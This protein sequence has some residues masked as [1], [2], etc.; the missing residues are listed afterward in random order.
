MSEIAKEAAR[1]TYH[2]LDG[3]RGLAALAVVTHHAGWMFGAA[4]MQHA[5]MAVD[6]FFV[7]SGFVLAHAYEPRFKTGLGPLRFM[8]LRLIRL[9]PLYIAGVL[10]GAAWIAWNLTQGTEVRLAQAQPWTWGELHTA[11]LTNAFF[12]PSPS[13]GAGPP[14]LYP[15]NIPAWSLLFEICVNLA[16]AVSALR[17]DTRLLAALVV[18]AGAVMA[19][20]GLKHGSLNAGWA[21]YDLEIA[22]VRVAFGFFAGVLI[23]RLSGRIPAW[24]RVHPILLLVVMIAAFVWTPGGQTLARFDVFCALILFPA[25]VLLGANT[26]PGRWTRPAYSFGGLTS[27]AVYAIHYPLC[28]VATVG[29]AV[30]GRDSAAN[31]PWSGVVFLAGLLG[32]AWILDRYYDAP[33]RAWLIRRTRPR[34]KAESVLA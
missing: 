20:M 32:L 33:L 3:M 26:E 10:I 18:V 12:L 27:Y 22:G 16:F 34:P 8:T 28:F 19:W 25:L 7:L 30:A 9:Y 4:Y 1:R 21:A 29:F 14:G 15:L 13:L 2:S 17:L 24:L 6:L 5:Y 31:A 23:H 11:L